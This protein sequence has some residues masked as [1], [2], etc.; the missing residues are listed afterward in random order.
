MPPDY[1]G[2]EAG[3]NF[4]TDFAKVNMMS[5]QYEE[6]QKKLQP[7]SQTELYEEGQRAERVSTHG[8][9][10]EMLMQDAEY[11]ERQL[12]ERAQDVKMRSGMMLGRRSGLQAPS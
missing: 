10:S 6:Q 12:E 9:T 11:I 8:I 3:Y 2:E 1:G 7:K 5:T 4:S